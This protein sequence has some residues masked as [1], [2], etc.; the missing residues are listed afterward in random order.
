[1]PDACVI[2]FDDRFGRA[3]SA[4][5]AVSLERLEVDY[6][7]DMRPLT[8]DRGTVGVVQPTPAHLPEGVG[9]TLSR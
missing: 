5:D 6:H 2:P 9:P 7:G 1:L 3:E 8:S 4:A